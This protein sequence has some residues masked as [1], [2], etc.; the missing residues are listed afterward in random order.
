MNK[1]TNLLV[2]GGRG[3]VG[4]N[5][6]NTLFYM[7]PNIQWIVIGLTSEKEKQTINSDIIN[8]GKYIYYQCNIGNKYKINKILNKHNIE[9]VLDLAALM[10]WYLNKI[11]N[12]EFLINNVIN[13][14]IF[15][16]TCVKYGK[17]KHIIYQSAI[18]C[19]IDNYNNYNLSKN[20]YAKNKYQQTLYNS[21]K[22]EGLTFAHNLLTQ[23]KIPITI[24][25]PTHIYGGNNQAPEDFILTYI[26]DLNANNKITLNRNSDV[27][28]GTWIE[29]FD[30][31]SAYDIIFS[32]GFNSTNYNLFNSDEYYTELNIAQLIVRN[33]KNT[34]NYSKYITFDNS[35]Y[36]FIPNFK[37]YKL[38]T[39]F[40]KHQYKPS[41]NLIKE[42]KKITSFYK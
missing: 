40:P 20:I 12:E 29:I 39:N 7:Y 4:S 1:I 22:I 41:N 3:Y 23:K 25:F 28:Y 13:R 33:I 32:Q 19:N 17:I 36:T 37:D 24:V 27:N 18:F 38:S 30:V 26:R 34:T 16:N 2:T 8:S 21:S 15:F 11:T 42:V 5:T 10:P 35:I 9:Y 14:K 6:I 31:I